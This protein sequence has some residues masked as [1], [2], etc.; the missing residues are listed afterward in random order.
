MFKKPSDVLFEGRPHY[1]VNPSFVL[2]QSAQTADAWIGGALLTTGFFGQFVDSAGWQPEWACLA[3]TLPAAGAIAVGS[4]ATLVWVIRPWN[5]RRVI[6]GVLGT[7][8]KLGREAD[9]WRPTVIWL[10][11][12][13][14]REIKEG[15]HPAELA[16]WLMGEER[17]QQLVKS[18]DVPEHMAEPYHPG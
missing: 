14:G 2:S 1:G 3:L 17:W 13:K 8:R 9:E 18:G 11:R 6:E 4:L 10:A 7:L 12:T 5:E 15:E 16:V